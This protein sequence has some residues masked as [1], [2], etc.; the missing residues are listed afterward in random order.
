M[1]EKDMNRGLRDN[2]GLRLMVLF[3]S[4]CFTLGL[5]AGLASVMTGT[6]SLDEGTVILF[7]S[8]VQCLLA[9][10]VPALVTGR[11]ASDKPVQWLGLNSIASGKS[12]LGV[13]LLYILALPAMNQLIVWNSSVHFPSWASGIET[14]FRSWEEANDNVARKI[15]D[16][17][18]MGGM[19][20]TI[21][22]VGI[23]TGFSEEIFFRGAMQ[24]ILQRTHMSEGVAVWVS[25]AIFSAIHFQ[26]FGF[27]PRLLMG[28]MF[29]YLFIWSKS[30]W[31]PVFAHA[32]NNSIVVVTSGMLG[33]E[34][35][36]DSFG[37]ASRGDMPYAA[38]TSA[39]ATFIFLWRFRKYFFFKVTEKQKRY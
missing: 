31:L 37:T 1:Y 23:L 11:F 24:G 22:V 15:L 10:C 4:F 17:S 27:V 2:A 19:A 13:V 36:I 35:G 26:F 16:Y 30:L 25:A 32:L 33:I 8:V 39:M 9:F 6:T 29:G 18:G 12:F 38:L 7:S 5:A 34:N 21:F 20:V 28:A 3:G 14:I